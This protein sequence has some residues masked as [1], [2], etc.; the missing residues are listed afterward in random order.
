MSFTIARQQWDEGTRHVARARRP[1]RDTMERVVEQ[2]AHE[3]RRRLGGAF[4]LDELASLYVEGVDWA[5]ALLH[6]LA[7]AVPAAWD[8]RVIDAAFARYARQAE[9][10]AG[11]RR[12]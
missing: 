8:S 5:L 12:R 9:D 1:E 4:T 3:L 6:D 10:Y 7:P 2:L 11:G